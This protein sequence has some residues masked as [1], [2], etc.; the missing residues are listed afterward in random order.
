M[1]K[2][3]YIVV[4]IV[5]LFLS[6]IFLTNIFLYQPIL[7]HLEKRFEKKWGCQVEKRKVELSFLKGSLR[8][9]GI[10]ITP[11]ENAAS[12]WNLS[13][14]E[15]FIQIDYPSLI[16]GN[17]ILDKLTLDKVVFKQNKKEGSDIR[18]KD[19]L[20]EIIKK[21]A[22]SEHFQKRKA[23]SR[24]PRKAILIRY[25]LIRDGYFEFYYRENSGKEY[26]LKLEH[27]N[28]SK[29]DLLLGRKL[30]VFF[31]SLFEG[32]EGLGR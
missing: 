27:V 32:L 12:R 26:R 30:D 5:F 8:F 25:F 1:K 13:A 16:S 22:K 31:R 6:L 7:D 20:P 24:S 10:H 21:E 9:K 17:T 15:I 19:I 18:R 14:D 4:I 11:P 29:K 28:L 23:F 2:I 3:R